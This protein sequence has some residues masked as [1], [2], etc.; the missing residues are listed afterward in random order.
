MTAT[1]PET[2]PATD[3]ETA[4]ATDP[5]PPSPRK[6]G[7]PKK[8]TA[9]QIVAVE[10]PPEADPPPPKDPEAEAA[11]AAAAAAEER[12]KAK[13]AAAATAAEA[14]RRE[15]LAGTKIDDAAEAIVSWCYTHPDSALAG[16]PV[17]PLPLIAA[18]MLAADARAVISAATT[19]QL[20]R[21]GRAIVYVP[22]A[23][24]ASSI[25]ARRVGLLPPRSGS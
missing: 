18:V 10:T 24:G 25:A 21:A 17:G 22:L 6:R 13:A 11:D 19:E 12:R 20:L 15:L 4:P 14:Y 23:V 2:A 9:A 5:P 1:A 8:S 16:L 3:P 7:R